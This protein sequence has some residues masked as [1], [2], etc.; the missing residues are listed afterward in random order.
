MKNVDFKSLKGL[1]VVGSKINQ[2]T[3]SEPVIMTYVTTIAYYPNGNSTVLR[4]F[5]TMKKQ[6]WL[7]DRKKKQSLPTDSVE[8]ENIEM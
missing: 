3:P 1:G 7:N 4:R 2:Q 5:S 8:G 6:H